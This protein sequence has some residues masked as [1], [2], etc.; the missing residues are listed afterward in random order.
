MI[1][2]VEKEGNIQDAMAGYVFVKYVMDDPISD[3]Y[4]VFFVL[5]FLK[6][7]LN[8]RIMGPTSVA[9]ICTT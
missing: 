7:N 3:F 1:L 9:V 4:F 6:I 8:S 5:P 2:L